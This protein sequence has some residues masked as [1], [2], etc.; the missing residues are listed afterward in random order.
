MLLGDRI[1]EINDVR[2][3]DWTRDGTTA[4]CKRF[5]QET[6]VV[7]R[8]ILEITGDTLYSFVFDTRISS[9]K[10]YSSERWEESDTGSVTR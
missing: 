9:V 10:Y 8:R 5:Y 1:D 7:R 2:E 6:N 4:I 3:I